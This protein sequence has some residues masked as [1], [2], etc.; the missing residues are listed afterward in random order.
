MVP[1]GREVSARSLAV[2]L[3]KRDEFWP[4]ALQA[5][6]VREKLLGRQSPHSLNLPR[7]QKP[8]CLP[9]VR[10][11]PMLILPLIAARTKPYRVWTRLL[12]SPGAG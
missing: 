6:Q 3:P 12:T 7:L 11:D 2:L 5:E 8:I 4:G 10:Y 1:R 9:L